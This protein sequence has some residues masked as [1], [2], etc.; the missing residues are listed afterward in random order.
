MMQQA[1]KTHLAVK[2]TRVGGIDANE[3]GASW[4]SGRSGRRRSSGWTG[5][6]ASRPIGFIS[7]FEGPVAFVKAKNIID[8]VVLDEI[9]EV[10]KYEAMTLVDRL[11]MVNSPPRATQIETVKKNK[12][13]IVKPP[14]GPLKFVPRAMRP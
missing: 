12:H 5:P 9:C 4:N 8:W 14:P 11:L 3:T 7:E 10:V 6:I 2:E 13:I 1:N